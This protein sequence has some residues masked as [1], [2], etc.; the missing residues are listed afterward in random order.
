VQGIE[1]RVQRAGIGFRV[2]GSRVWGSGS[3][4]KGLGI[5]FEGLGFRV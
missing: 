2:Q 3:T 4:I 1:C 5:R